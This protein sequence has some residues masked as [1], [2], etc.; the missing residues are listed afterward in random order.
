MNNMNIKSLLMVPVFLLS[1]NEVSAQVSNFQNEI[2]ELS[3][4]IGISQ[5]AGLKE[6]LSN[7]LEVDTTKMDIFIKGVYEGAAYAKDSEKNA[8]YAGVQIGQQIA[9]KMIS[10]INKEIFGENSEETISLKQFLEGFSKGI[11]LNPHEI[12]SSQK[13]LEELLINV[14]AAALE[15]EK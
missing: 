2:E 6:Y 7:T 8:Y 3:Y 11:L 5:T 15:N 12:Q 9:L 1:S 4:H 14:K 10:G 13:K